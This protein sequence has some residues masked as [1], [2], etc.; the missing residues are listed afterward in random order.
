M[1]ALLYLV[2]YEVQITAHDVET[3]RPCGNKHY[4]KTALATVPPAY[5]TAI[6]GSGSTATLLA[7]FWTN[8]QAFMATSMSM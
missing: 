5:G 8:Y 1:A 7:N 3:L 6:P 2:P 4:L